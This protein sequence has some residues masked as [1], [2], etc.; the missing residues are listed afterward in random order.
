MS[1]PHLNSGGSIVN[2]ASGRSRWRWGA[3][4]AALRYV[5]RAVMITRD[6]YKELGPRNIRVNCVC[7]GMIN[8]TFHDTFY[9]R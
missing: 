8:T 2:L 5:K 4:A 3:G 7:P 1:A 9:R 6:G